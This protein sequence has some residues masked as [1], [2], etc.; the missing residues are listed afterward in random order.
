MKF[1]FIEIKKIKIFLPLILLLI[2][3]I[4]SGHISKLKLKGSLNTV[5]KFKFLFMLKWPSVRNDKSN[6]LNV[7]TYKNVLLSTSQVVYFASSNSL[8]AVRDVNISIKHSK[9]TNP[10]TPHTIFLRCDM[11]T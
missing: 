11:L 8:S 10:G 5:E 7:L 6:P 9:L 3:T 4:S 1:A 2:S